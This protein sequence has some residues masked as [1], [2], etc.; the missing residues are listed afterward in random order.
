MS[1]ETIGVAIV[2]AVI[3]LAVILK[4]GRA[5]NDKLR[6]AIRSEVAEN[7][8]LSK[9]DAESRKMAVI[10]LDT[11]LGKALAY[12]GIKGETV[13]ERL[14]QA[15]RIFEKDQ[16]NALWAAHKMRNTIVHEN[17]TPTLKELEKATTVFSSAIKRLVN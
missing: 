2:V 9:G 16:Y 15:G 14:K 13:G 5:G 7:L 17:N 12:Y 4:I 1:G 6:D 10:N 8:S 11:L 3:L